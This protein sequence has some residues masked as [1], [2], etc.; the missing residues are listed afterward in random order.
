[1]YVSGLPEQIQKET[2]REHFEKFGEIVD[3]FVIKKSGFAIAF[4]TFDN[5]ESSK[6]AISEMNQQEVEGKMIRCAQAKPRQ[7]RG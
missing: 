7:P 4:V 2:L 3:L 5:H 1:M 6:N